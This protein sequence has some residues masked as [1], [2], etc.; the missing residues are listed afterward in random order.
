MCGFVAIL[1]KQKSV[2]ELH[3]MAQ[4]VA[5]RGP[6]DSG[7]YTEKY[8]AAVHHRLAII[9]ADARGHQ[10]MCIDDVITVFNGCI[11]NYHALRSRLEQDGVRFQSD[12]DTEVLPHLYRRFGT[13]MFAMLQGMFSMVLWDKREQ[14]CLI[15]RDAFGEKPLFVCE[16]GGRIGFSSLLSGFEKGDWSLSPDLHAVHDVL[17]NMRVEAP[18]TMYQ[19]VAQLPAGCYAIARA[20]EAIAIRRYHFLPEADQPLDISPSEI[21]SEVKTLLED[22]FTMR[23]VSDK[24]L[25]V[26]L[27]GGVDSSLIAGILAQKVDHPLHTFSVKFSGGT[28]DYDESTFAQT[29]ADHLGTNHQTLEVSA[30]AHDC[31]NKLALAFDQPVTNS[32]ALPMYLI[33]QAAKPYVDVA[34]SGVGGDELFGGYPRYLGM[35]WQQKLRHLPARNMAL[36]CLQKF[37]DSDSSRNI[38]GRAR[39]FLQGLNLNPDQAY[40]QWMQT[41]QSTWTEMF[42]QP[43]P[44]HHQQSWQSA[45]GTYG[46]LA[47][48]LQRYGAVNGAMAY[49]VLTYLNDD[50]LAMGDRMSMA[51]GLELRAPFLDTRLLALMTTLDTSWKLKGMPWQ[52]HLKVMLKSIATDYVPYDMVHRPKQGFMAPIKHWLRSDLAQ[53]VENLI[54]SNPLGG[55]VRREFIRE[56]WHR[57]QHGEDRSD[58]LW[59]LLLMNR[60]MEQRGW[61]F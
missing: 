21:Q 52:E 6:D 35:A 33:S 23:L 42:T 30:N 1:G 27:S 39:R 3:R 46:G 57:H 15:G 13:A 43:L 22:A 48:L 2:G 60:W 61:K 10:P 26:F 29:V 24:P 14:Q 40:Q 50:L 16:Q 8:F 47:G 28:A 7:E 34:L 9:G 49:D 25:G 59:G 32:A 20:G 18:A 45:A 41:T 12:S 17:V 11:Y 4:A 53:D 5:M 36:A 51:H 58:I 54:S 56:Q 31:L 37:G 55:L 19:E 44:N 38:R